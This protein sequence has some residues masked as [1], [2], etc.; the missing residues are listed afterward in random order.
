[1][2]FYFSEIL[3]YF[4]NPISEPSKIRQIYSLMSFVNERSS[5]CSISI[6]IC[7]KGIRFI[8]IITKGRPS[9]KSHSN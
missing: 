3:M 1:M 2:E 6:S 9:I 7:I 4:S 8:K 5:I